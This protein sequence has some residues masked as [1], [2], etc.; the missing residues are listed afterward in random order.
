VYVGTLRA[1]SVI[2]SVIGAV[3]PVTIA[4]PSTVVEWLGPAAASPQIFAFWSRVTFPSE[5]TSPFEFAY[6]LE[7]EPFV[8]CAAYVP[9]SEL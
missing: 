6:M 3:E 2:G 5:P 1:G 7:P 8:A 9:T 4:L